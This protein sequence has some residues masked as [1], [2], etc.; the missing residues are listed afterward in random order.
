MF[1]QRPFL[2]IQLREVNTSSDDLHETAD[3]SVISVLYGA[4]QL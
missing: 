4:F 1:R 2:E 3:I